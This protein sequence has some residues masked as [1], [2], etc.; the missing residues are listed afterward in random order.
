MN[1]DNGHTSEGIQAAD[2]IDVFPSHVRRRMVDYLHRLAEVYR[3]Q[4]P[5]PQVELPLMPRH[6]PPSLD[7]D[8]IVLSDRRNR[9]N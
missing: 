5:E 2:E 3:L 4:P 6:E 9:A 8:V 7:P 1:I